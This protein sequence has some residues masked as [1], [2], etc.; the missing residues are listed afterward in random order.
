MFRPEM[1]A[2]TV[3]LSHYAYRSRDAAASAV[4]GEGLQSF[5][6]FDGP[7]TQAITATSDEHVFLAFRGTESHDPVDWARDAQ[8]VP[9]LGELGGRVHSG[10]RAALG[11]VWVAVEGALE[12]TA[13]PIVVT[14]HSLGAGLAV[15]SAARAV[16]AG[17]DVAAVYLYGCPR[18]GLSD[19][20]SAY[21]RQLG[22]VTYNV[23]NHIDLVTRVPLLAQGFRH[24][25]MRMYF[26]A[27]GAFHEDAGAWHIA[28]DDVRYRLRHFGRIQSIGLGSHEISAYVNAIEELAR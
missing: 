22:S 4:A 11:E 14:G 12:A 8:F 16:V 19:F 3:R 24:V 13:R 21:D 20:R 27:F 5:R 10:F 26:D 9:Q 15:L 17:M 7:S 28:L 25:G 6:F 1:A 23:I 18:P 2:R